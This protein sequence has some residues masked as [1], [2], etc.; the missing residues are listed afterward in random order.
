VTGGAP[1]V[2]VH[3]GKKWNKVFIVLGWE[4]SVN[5]MAAAFRVE[6]WHEDFGFWCRSFEC[7]VEFWVI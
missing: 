7:S 4:F 6:F 1:T 5:I 3:Q 2:I